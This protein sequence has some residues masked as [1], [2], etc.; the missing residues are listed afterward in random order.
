MGI[1]DGKVA[2]IT[3]SGSGMGRAAAV[4]MGGEGAFVVVADIREDAAAETV[5]S[6]SR[7]GARPRCL[8]STSAASIRSKH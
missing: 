4:R 6:S 2:V 5:S 1:L 8:R 3:A 7:Q